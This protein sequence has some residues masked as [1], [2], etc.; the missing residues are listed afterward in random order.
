MLQGRRRAGKV[1]STK[2]TRAAATLDADLAC[3]GAGGVNQAGQN[4]LEIGGKSYDS[5]SA[6]EG[7]T[8]ETERNTRNAE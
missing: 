2:H 1:V 3:S 4:R 5:H 6:V 8:K 7:S